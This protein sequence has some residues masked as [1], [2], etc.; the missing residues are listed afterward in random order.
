MGIGGRR[1]R[2]RAG[3]VLPAIVALEAGIAILD[4]ATPQDVPISHLYYVPIVLAAGLYGYA[5]AAA[6]SCSAL[7]LFI[8]SNYVWS[9]SRSPQLLAPATALTFLFYLAVG[10]A[11]AAFFGHQRA[12]SDTGERLRARVTELDTLNRVAATLAAHDDLDVTLRAILAAVGEL[13]LAAQAGIVPFAAAEDSLARAVVLGDHARRSPLSPALLARI[14]ASGQPLALEA[15]TPEGATLTPPWRALLALPLAVG[16]EPVGALYAA[17]VRPRR[18]TADERRTLETLAQ[19]AADAIARAGLR[20][21]ELDLALAAERSRLAREIHDTLAQ[22]LLTVILQLEV[23]KGL[24]PGD[25]GRAHDEARRAEATA[26]EALAEARRSVRGLRPT[27]LERGTLVEALRAEACAFAER[28]GVAVDVAVEGEPVP[29]AEA[30][31]DGLFGIAREA[32]NNVRKHA[33]ARAVVLRLAF[34]GDAVTLTVRDDGA[35]FDPAAA[36]AG[37]RAGR[38]GLVG[39][40]ERARLLGGS[41]AITSAPGAGAELAVTLPCRPA[42]GAGR[43]VRVLLCDDHTL[44]RRGVA[45]VLRA[46]GAIGIVGEAARGE[47]ALRLAAQ[48]RPD[49]VLLD[50]RLPDLDGVAVTARLSAADPHVAVVLLTTF[51]DDPALLEALRAGARGCLLKDTPADALVAAVHA[52]ARGDPVLA[53]PVADRLL[54]QWRAAPDAAEAP[55]GALS[56]REMEVLH[57]LAAGARNKEIARALGITERTAKAHVSHIL[58]KLAAA[59]R[60]AAVTTAVRQG[61]LRL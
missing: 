49:V 14:S 30:S 58:Q 61:L 32:L 38:F 51:G 60:T 24:L 43:P 26:R 4:A 44:V 25:P 48:A 15:G 22:S 16:G 40:R 10:T 29:L 39:M 20:A 31:E 35:G 1:R 36:T 11:A 42:P 45:D 46:D 19:Q 52:A 9:A 3:A 7:L 37:E 5:G 55:A 33:R 6:A 28:E 23:V 57:L 59:D 47:E 34:T 56:A 18:Y 54:T 13:G 8:L 17:D 12:L 2:W 53:S 27:V 41:L 21:Q 50:L